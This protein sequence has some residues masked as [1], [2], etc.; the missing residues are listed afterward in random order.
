[1]KSPLINNFSQVNYSKIVFFVLALLIFFSTAIY[2]SIQLLSVKGKE[3]YQEINSPPLLSPFNGRVLIFLLDSTRKDSMF[4]ENMPYISNLREKGAWGIS[5]VISTPLSVAGDNAIF[6]GVVSGPFSFLDDFSGKPSAYDNLFKRVTLQNKRAIIFSS[7]CLRGAYGKYTDFSAFVPKNFL[8][9]QYREDAKYLFDQ[10]YDFLKQ[11]EWDLAAV[12]FITMD[13]IG[14]L[15]T[16]HSPDY[17]PELKLLDN[18]VRQ[19]VE[20]TT[21]EDIVLITS[22]HGMDDNG[23]HVDRTEFVIETPFILTGPGINKGGPKEVLQIDWAPT[24]SLL[25]GVS[26]FYASPALPAIDLL[27]LPPEYS[28]GLIRTFSKRI[29]GNSNISSLDEL[30]KIRLTKMERKSSPALCILI[31][32]ATL[33]SLILF[34]FVALSS[35]DYSG[36]ISPK[37]KYIM[38]GIFGLCALTG[39]ELYFGILDYISDNFPFSANNILDNPIKI[40]LAFILMVILPIYYGKITKTVET[41]SGNVALPF[42]LTLIFSIALIVTNPYHPLNWTI[43]CIPLF[44]WGV[45]RHPAWLVI[46]FA[47]LAGMSIR[48]LTFYNVYHHITMPDRWAFSLMVLFIGIA[49]LLWRLRHDKNRVPIVGY[50][51]IGVL[52]CIV[53]IAWPSSAGVKVIL[54]LL[55]LIPLIFVSRRI[56]KIS[57]VLLALW[58]VFFYL[59]TSSNINHLSHIVALPL[60]LAVWSLSKKASALT[61]GSMISLAIWTLFL[62]PGN[63]F[64]L[65]ILELRDKFIL[66]SAVTKQIELTALVIASRYIIPT[67]ILIW[68]VKQT[69]PRMSLLSMFSITIFPIVFG[70]GISLTIWAS[71]TFI[72]YP[73][74][75]FTKLTILFGFSFIIGC[76]FLIVSVS[77]NFIHPYYLK[78]R[79]K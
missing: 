56:P 9:S 25:A 59:G 30:R 73:W 70:I 24:L 36:I 49:F 17:I 27:S 19:L 28:S 29:T 66:G 75:L 62:L 52:P 1:M 57:D 69:A 21:D 42:F 71:S 64:D 8:F 60:L 31:V 10:T 77:T 39:M 32:L 79:D 48:R 72:E 37:M 41:H 58:I 68:M 7:H 44:S 54:L 74:N 63:E 53:V 33:C 38:L 18:Y 6:S 22:E 55:S 3:D 12:Q 14:H 35:N 13:F 46:F 2:T 11:K 34:A 47:I 40:V 50:G 43:V 51:I 67:T 76:A 65:K 61:Q 5:R 20:L 16:P 78:L 26:P 23:F 15:E 4:S 45:T